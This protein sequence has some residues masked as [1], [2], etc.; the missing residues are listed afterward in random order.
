MSASLLPLQK[1]DKIMT[2]ILVTNLSQ[3]IDCDEFVTEK[4]AS[5]NLWS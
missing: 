4:C 1:H 3:I 2:E 5:Q